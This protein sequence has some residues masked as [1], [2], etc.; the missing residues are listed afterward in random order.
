MRRDVAAGAN[1]CAAPPDSPAAGGLA[2]PA[3][4]PRSPSEA[5]GSGR[6][7]S[8]PIA[9][10]GRSTRK[11]E[12]EAEPWPGFAASWRA[13]ALREAGSAASRTGWRRENS[14]ISTGR[15]MQD[16]DRRQQHS[17]DHDER[18]R[19]LH[20]AADRRSRPRPAAGRRRRRCR[21]S[22][23]G[24]ICICAGPHTRRPPGRRRR[25]SAGCSRTCTMM[26]SMAE[27]PNKRDE[28]DRGRDAERHAGE[29]QREDAADQRHRH[30]A[31]RE[32]RVAS[33]S[34]N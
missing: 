24:R 4:R 25:R 20:L 18:Q 7:K 22:A 27:M 13:S 19:L 21:S 3:A 11:G 28:A 30:H 17:A 29:I 8:G 23:P 15:T 9:Q 33:S 16:Q 31:G 5:G 2:R 1:R 32:Q 10:P 12:E 26:P 34:R 14:S 6:W